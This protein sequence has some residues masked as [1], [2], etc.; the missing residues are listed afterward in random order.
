MCKED[1]NIE[2]KQTFLSSAISDVST[3][4]QLV[5]SKVSIIMAAVVAILVG[6]AACYE[7][8]GKAMNKIIPSSWH[9]IL[10]LLFL[11]LCVIS[12]ALVLIFGIL[13]IKWHSCKIDYKSKWYITKS[14]K[15]YSFKEYYKDISRM[16]DED[17]I[18]NMS[19]ELYKLNDINQQKAKTMKVTIIGFSTFLI[20]I[21]I[22]VI[23]LLITLI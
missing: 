7:P 12:I 13:T 20:S 2:N 4:I 23:L 14:S 3:Y 15:E 8:I 19:A 5:D 18:E 21:S 1:F 10:T 9:V 6:I 16:T 17:I 22:I 11:I